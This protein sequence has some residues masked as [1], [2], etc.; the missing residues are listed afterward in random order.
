MPD[1]KFSLPNSTQKSPINFFNIFTILKTINLPNSTTRVKK[2]RTSLASICLSTLLNMF[3]FVNHLCVHHH[4]HHI[5]QSF[6]H[7]NP[8]RPF[9]LPT[10]L[11]HKV[12]HK[13]VLCQRLKLQELHI[14]PHPVHNRRGT[15]QRHGFH[16]R[17]RPRA[18]KRSHHQ[19]L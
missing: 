16:G 2:Q 8:N 19:A 17:L 6:I 3:L 15:V 12:R 18:R 7:S 4:H 10:F 5:I 1:L 14:Q 11:S 13:R 9:S